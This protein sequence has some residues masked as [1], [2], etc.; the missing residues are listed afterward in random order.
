MT[1]PEIKRLARSLG[2][3]T[4]ENY[5]PAGTE[6]QATEPPRRKPGRPRKSPE[7]S[8]SIADEPALDSE[9]IA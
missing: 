1:E 5:A 9:P 7:T 6:D 8:S 3:W 2:V 4:Q